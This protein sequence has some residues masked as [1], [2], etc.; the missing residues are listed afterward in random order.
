M[1]DLEAIRKKLEESR[2]A[3]EKAVKGA[4]QAGVA[5]AKANAAQTDRTK[6]PGSAAQ[7]AAAK[8][9]ASAAQAL[10]GGTSKGA[11]TYTRKDGG[12]YA[13]NPQAARYTTGRKAHEYAPYRQKLVTDTLQAGEDA[14]SRAQETGVKNV[15]SLYQELL[16]QAA[17][18]EARSDDAAAW[19]EESAGTGNG[20]AAKWYASAARATGEQAAALGAEARRL[21][22]GESNRQELDRLEKLGMSER[23]LVDRIQGSGAR[24]LTAEEQQDAAASTRTDIAGAEAELERMRREGAS[25]EDIYY[26]QFYVDSLK[27][28]ETRLD[29]GAPAASYESDYESWS[30]APYELA[31]VRS[32]YGQTQQNIDF[33]EE[34]IA[35][36]RSQAEQDGLISGLQRAMERD[37]VTAEDYNSEYLRMQLEQQNKSGL[38]RAFTDDTK[39]N[40]TAEEY[41][42]LRYAQENYPGSAGALEELL[43]ARADGRGNARLEEMLTD[44]ERHEVRI[45][46]GKKLHGPSVR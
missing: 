22:S 16:A 29:S 19:A 28:A 6:T 33:I 17:G 11:R 5:R 34:E 35:E 15:G 14:L 43:D 36:E 38:K 2:A 24:V 4:A 20:L 37:G 46:M 32:D 31:D 3:R 30:A 8:T 44:P 9:A 39:E 10:K 40:Y 45:E 27:K 23:A 7:A 13:G 18:A 25:E 21:V 41:A 26:Q 42:L 1:A 12:S